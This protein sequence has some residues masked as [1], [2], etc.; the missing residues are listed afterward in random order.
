MIGEIDRM[1]I[2]KKTPPD[3]LLLTSGTV[4]IGITLRSDSTTV[5]LVCYI[6]RMIGEFER[7]VIPKKT[8]PDHLLLTSGTVLIGITLRSDS[9][10]VT[11]R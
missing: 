8:P 11:I 1:R 6:N 4:L 3:H 9:T 10:T 7:M 5:T 2:P